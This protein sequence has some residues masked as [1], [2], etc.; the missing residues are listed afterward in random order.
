MAALTKHDK[1]AQGIVL[2]TVL[3]MIITWFLDPSEVPYVLIVG[4]LVSI[5]HRH[6]NL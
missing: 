4:G 2:L 6:P 1:E 5:F 3:G